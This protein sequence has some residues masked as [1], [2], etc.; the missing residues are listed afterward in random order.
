M[1]Q[2]VSA[3][4]KSAK[5]RLKNRWGTAPEATDLRTLIYKRLVEALGNIMFAHR[6][7]TDDFLRGVFEELLTKRREIFR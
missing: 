6:D 5:A 3:K 4:K 7:M 2:R 1:G